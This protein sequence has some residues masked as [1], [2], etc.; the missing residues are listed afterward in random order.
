MLNFTVGPVQSSQEVLDIGAENTPY[1]RTSE[2]SQIMKENEACMLELLHAPEGSR[3]LFLTASGSG[4]MEA[5]VINCLDSQDKALVV[6]GGSFGHRFDE[7]LTIHD[8]DHDNIFLKPGQP[9]TAQ[10]LK[11]FEN[12][13]Y[14]AFLV[15]IHETSTGILYDKE[16]IADFCRR[17]Q[18]FLIVDAISS[19]LSDPLDME[20][21]GADVVIAGSQKALACPPGIALVTLSPA[22][23]KRV[24]RIDP[25]SLYF[26]FKSM[27]KNGERGQT[28]FTP[29]VSILLQL[30]AR[31]Q[32]ATARGVDAEVAGPARL[33]EDFRTRAAKLPLELRLVSPS[34]TCTYCTIS[35]G[36]A[37]ELFRRLID[38]YQIWICPNGGDNKD[39]SFRVGH[40]GELS[41]EDNTTLLKALEELH[42]RGIF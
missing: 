18:L 7:I 42:D 36:G 38:E 5:A 10:D 15:N 8:I 11:P 24:E 31:L 9:L 33:A 32:Q 16:L 14:T 13:G 22:A 41:L 37:E 40:I 35:Q 26:D 34:N 30:H 6:N 39:T 21:M 4:G 29:A 2:F 20:A 12:K 19:F 28:P 27:L 17:N 3:Q 1:F 23:I 25:H